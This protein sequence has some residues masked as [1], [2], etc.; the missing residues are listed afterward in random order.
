MACYHIVVL[1]S[2]Y[3]PHLHQSIVII[4]AFGNVGTLKMSPF[5]ESERFQINKQRDG[6]YVV[7]HSYR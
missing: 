3:F 7:G 5:T 1:I 4:K 2:R 6:K